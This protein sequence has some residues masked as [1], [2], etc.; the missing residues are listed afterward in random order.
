M[1]CQ[2]DPREEY[3][4]EFE[5]RNTS[6]QARKCISKW[7]LR[8]CGYFVRSLDMIKAWY[9]NPVVCNHIAFICEAR[10]EL[11]VASESGGIQY[12]YISHR[13]ILDVQIQSMVSMFKAENVLFTKYDFVD[14]NI[15]GRKVNFFINF[16]LLF[17]CAKIWDLFGMMVLHRSICNHPTS[18]LI[19][20]DFVE[21][22]S[23]FFQNYHNRR[24][25]TH[26]KR[27]CMMRVLFFLFAIF[28]S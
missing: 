28:I 4:V 14:T 21:T 6:F 13:R 20:N 22:W 5:S 25:I 23:F 7:R 3:L 8:D 10:P 12:M 18:Q 11:W 15:S 27:W 24:P 1:Y 19:L 26:L 17:T 16:K 9:S 2:L